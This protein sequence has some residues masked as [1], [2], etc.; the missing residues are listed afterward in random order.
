MQLR[1]LPMLALF[2]VMFP[3]HFL[4]LEMHESRVEDRLAPV[5]FCAVLTVN[6]G[7]FLSCLVADPNQTAMNEQGTDWMIGIEPQ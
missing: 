2:S 6:R 5:I 7:L 3:A 4:T 1:K